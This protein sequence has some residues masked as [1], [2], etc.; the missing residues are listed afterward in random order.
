MCRCYVVD[1][2]V[3]KWQPSEGV[4]QEEDEVASGAEHLRWS[5]TSVEVWAE[6]SEGFRRSECDRHSDDYW[7]ADG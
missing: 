4:L 5:W 1:F 7:I 6:L 3:S 2:V